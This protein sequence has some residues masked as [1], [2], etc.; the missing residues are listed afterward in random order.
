M[1]IKKN[2]IKDHIIYY[3]RLHTPGIHCY[4]WN[5]EHPHYYYFTTILNSAGSVSVRTFVIQYC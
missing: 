1:K 3:K 4:L 2:E 5:P